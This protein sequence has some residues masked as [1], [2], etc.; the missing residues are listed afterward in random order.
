MIVIIEFFW[1]MPVKQMRFEFRG[2]SAEKD[3]DEFE[4]LMVCEKQFIQ[5]R[6]TIRRT[7]LIFN[8]S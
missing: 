5:I 3:A 2:P 1:S 7:Y 4:E 6:I 8:S